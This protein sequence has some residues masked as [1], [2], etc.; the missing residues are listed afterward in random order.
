M[1]FRSSREEE[2]KIKKNVEDKE[3]ETDKPIVTDMV[4]ATEVELQTELMNDF[5][6]GKERPNDE[7]ILS[8]S[9]YFLQDS[10]V[11]SPF[12]DQRDTE[13]V[14]NM[15]WHKV[16][17]KDASVQNEPNADMENL[18][19]NDIK[20]E[21][22]KK[23]VSIMNYMIENISDLDKDNN[24]DW[25]LDPNE[26]NEIIRSIIKNGH[27]LT[28]L[29]RNLYKK[30][31]INNTDNDILLNDMFTQTNPLLIKNSDIKILEDN[32]KSYNGKLWRDEEVQVIMPPIVDKSIVEKK[33]PPYF[34]YD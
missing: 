12:I 18:I 33:T 14:S 10:K 26:D 17:M 8:L 31:G 2:K 23:L 29:L 11:M 32:V 22:G 21:L 28:I 4:V 34:I 15:L 27:L 30:K 6:I 9:G 7:D 20:H 19:M 13:E 5:F 3:I 16:Y 25:I 24:G 1:L